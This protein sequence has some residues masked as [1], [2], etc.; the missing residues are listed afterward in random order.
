MMQQAITW[1]NARQAQWHHI[2][3]SDVEELIK[4]DSGFY[5]DTWEWVILHT[6]A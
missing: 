3:T 6:M 4:Y 2:A 5:I 1:F